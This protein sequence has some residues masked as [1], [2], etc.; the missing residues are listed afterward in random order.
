M[1]LIMNSC[2]VKNSL[3]VQNVSLSKVHFLSMILT[4]EDEGS[5]DT[6]VAEEGGASEV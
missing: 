4:A 3:I 6:H 1:L 2:R 5:S